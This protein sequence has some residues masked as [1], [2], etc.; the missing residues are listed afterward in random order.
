[1]ALC[2]YLI[3]AAEPSGTSLL[4]LAAARPGDAAEKLATALG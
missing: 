2:H 3:R 4:I 1:M